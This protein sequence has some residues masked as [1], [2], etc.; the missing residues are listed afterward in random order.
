[1]LDVG[2]GWGSL[3]IHAARERGA[4]V[5]G[6]TLSEPQAALAAERARA[7]GVGDQGGVPGARLP[8][9]R[10]GALRRDRKHRDGRA[11]R[12]AQIDGY[13]AKLATL[14]RPDGRLLNHGITHVPPEPAGGYSGGP[15]LQRYVFPDA[16]LL[17]LW[18]MQAAFDRAGL[19]TLH[20]ENLHPHYAETLR[21]WTQR[22][23]ANLGG[24]G[25]FGRPRAPPRLAS[26]PA[27]GA[28]QLRD[29]PERGLSDPVLGSD[30]RA[31]NGA[32]AQPP[33]RAPGAERLRAATASAVKPTSSAYEKMFTA[34]A[35][36]RPRTTSEIIACTAMAIFAQA[37]SGI[38]SVGLNA[39]AL[40]KPRYR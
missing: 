23:E 25:A 4:E 17:N 27:R 1:M 3:A 15:F 19:E 14:L 40:V 31:G 24:G 33:T 20:I 28:Q 39:V 2:C 7:A 34:R 21:H 11:R 30:H 10:R 32:T 13:A 35:I 6:V 29:R 36:T 8:R 26:L 9:A 18:R 5:I 12:R 16:E 37:A 22:L 38:A